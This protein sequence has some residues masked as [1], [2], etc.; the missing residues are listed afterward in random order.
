M[1]RV[2]KFKIKRKEEKKN[3]PHLQQMMMCRQQK[4]QQVFDAYAV[5]YQP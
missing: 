5:H 2:A 3:L 4:K 1:Q